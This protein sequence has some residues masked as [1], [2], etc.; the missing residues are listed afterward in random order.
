MKNPAV[1]LGVYALLITIVWTLIEHFLGY[2]SANHEVGQY[3]RQLGAFVFWIT[4]IVAIVQARR[5]QGGSL[6]FGQGMKAGR[7]VSFV[8]SLGI[9]AWYCL[10]GEV[11]NTQYRPTLIAFER[12]KL[13]SAHAAPDVI[14]AKMKEVEMTSGGSFLS[15]VFLFVFMFFSGMVVAI[16][17]SL[18]LKRKQ[19]KA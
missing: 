4:V 2:N 13:D 7:I 16:I 11:I 3:T 12:A 18:I 1:K 5:Q 8:Y 15:Y 10:Y 17:T 14:A 6:T 19:K 9:T